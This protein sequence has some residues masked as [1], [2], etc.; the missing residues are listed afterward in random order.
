M[1]VQKLDH[2]M[3]QY[4]VCLFLM[5]NKTK[6]H[7]SYFNRKQQGMGC[8]LNYLKIIHILRTHTIQERLQLYDLAE[9]A[10]RV[11]S[12][13]LFCLFLRRLLF[14][15]LASQSNQWLSTDGVLADMVS[16]Y[17]DVI[18]FLLQFFFS[19]ENNEMTPNFLLSAEIC[20]LPE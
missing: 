9:L 14:F 12:L 11:C 15:T 3:I 20:C 10:R 4:C 2:T 19:P 17:Q 13:I 16:L 8:F 6:K 5:K 1:A 7:H 18:Q